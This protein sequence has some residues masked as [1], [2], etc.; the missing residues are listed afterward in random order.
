MPGLI[1]DFAGDNL[2]TVTQLM[3]S[4]QDLWALD[5]DNPRIRTLGPWISPLFRILNCLGMACC[6]STIDVEALALHRAR[7]LVRRLN[8]SNRH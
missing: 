5:G 2:A 3:V 1:R 4:M 8:E 6:Y 7:H